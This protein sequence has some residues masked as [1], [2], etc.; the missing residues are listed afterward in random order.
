MPDIK[1]RTI[2]HFKRFNVK[3]TQIKGPK[4]DAF[5]VKARQVCMYVLKIELGLPFVEIGNL[6]G[7]RDHTT[8]MHGVDKIKV[9]VEKQ[10]VVY[11]DI[12][13][14]TKSLRG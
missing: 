11:E 7:G 6:L 8:I 1:A 2:S 3:T 12:L 10:S 14:I 9:F 4:R 5:L 13:G